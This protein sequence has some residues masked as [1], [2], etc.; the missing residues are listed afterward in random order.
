MDLRKGLSAADEI[1]AEGAIEVGVAMQ[2]PGGDG[3]MVLG[4]T[5]APSTVKEGGG[6][7]WSLAG[8]ANA[9][10]GSCPLNID[11]DSSSDVSMETMRPFPRGNAVELGGQGNA[12]ISAVVS[13]TGLGVD[14]SSVGFSECL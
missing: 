14:T 4:S 8:D 2:E 3:T 11:D 6:W 10:K 13:W 1:A 9:R 12:R 5:V 7:D